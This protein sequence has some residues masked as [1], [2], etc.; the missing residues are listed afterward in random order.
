[1]SFLSCIEFTNANTTSQIVI[2]CFRC[3]I[4]L[5]HVRSN[6]HQRTEHGSCSYCG[7]KYTRVIRWDTRRA[8]W[9]R[10]A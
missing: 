5:D 6:Q 1:M 7:K 9:W 2:T 10:A 4:H 8:D 3:V